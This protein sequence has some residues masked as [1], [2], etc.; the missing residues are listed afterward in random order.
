MI[1]FTAAYP[2]ST[3]DLLEEDEADHLVRE[4]HV[5]EGEGMAGRFPDT[6]CHAKR[7]TYQERDRRVAFKDP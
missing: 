4:G 6:G 5:G 2:G 7:A 3:V 1:R